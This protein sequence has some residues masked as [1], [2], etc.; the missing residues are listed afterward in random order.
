MKMVT[1]LLSIKFIKWFFKKQ[2]LKWLLD[3]KSPF[4]IEFKPNI[5][6]ISW[7][8]KF[9]KAAN[10][11]HVRVGA[12][13]L[14]ELGLRSRSLYLD[15]GLTLNIVLQRSPSG[16]VLV[17]NVSLNLNLNI[18]IVTKIKKKL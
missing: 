17:K 14:Q 2:G 1:I 13:L 18:L 8:W 6:M 16:Q 5:E 9:R 12:K 11:S 4:S 7:L 10:P 15:I 3:P